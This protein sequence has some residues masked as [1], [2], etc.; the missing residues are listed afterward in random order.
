MTTKIIINDMLHGKI[1]V[2]TA[3]ILK[4]EANL[5]G[6]PEGAKTMITCPPKEGID[7]FYHVRES[8]TEINAMIEKAQ[9]TGHAND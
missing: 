9:E 4:V 7:V 5:T 6:Y 1:S 2:N 3:S 8:V